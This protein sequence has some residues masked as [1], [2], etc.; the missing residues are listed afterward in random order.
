[1]HFEKHFVCR[2]HGGSQGISVSKGTGGEGRI[3]NN[4]DEKYVTDEKYAMDESPREVSMEEC[5]P[6]GSVFVS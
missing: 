5:E 3:K 1:M 6:R 2:F 4:L